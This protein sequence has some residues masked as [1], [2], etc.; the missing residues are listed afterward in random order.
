MVSPLRK[1]CSDVHFGSGRY[2]IIHHCQTL[3]IHF[4]NIPLFYCISL[5]YYLFYQQIPFIQSRNN[6]ILCIY[7][8]GFMKKRIL[9]T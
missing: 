3:V 4:N 2:C 7:T 6:S 5:I 9:A 1:V 8:I